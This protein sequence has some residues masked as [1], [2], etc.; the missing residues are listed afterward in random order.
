MWVARNAEGARTLGLPP[1]ECNRRRG[2]RAGVSAACHKALYTS[3][4]QPRALRIGDRVRIVRLPPMW[5]TPG[6]R[7]PASTRRVYQLMISRRR[8]VRIDNVD[9]WG[10]WVQVLIRG[11]RGLEHHHITPDDGCLVRVWSRRI[12]GAGNR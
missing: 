2:P 8:T 6:Y 7:V 11:K 10:A 12:P 3:L 5:S 4:M 9:D 1:K